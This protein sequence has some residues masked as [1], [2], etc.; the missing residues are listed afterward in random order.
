MYNY[1]IRDSSL[2]IIG[3]SDKIEIIDGRYCPVIYSNLI[4]DNLVSEDEQVILTF[5]AMLI[6]QE[7]DTDVFIGFLEYIEN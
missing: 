7:F 1:L 4:S 3:T 5:L 2:E 6:E